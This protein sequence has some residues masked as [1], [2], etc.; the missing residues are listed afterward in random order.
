MLQG[1]RVRVRSDAPSVEREF[2]LACGDENRQRCFSAAV[3]VRAQIAI[4]S[5]PRLSENVGNVE[6]RAGYI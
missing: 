1:K 2:I 4:V 3:R 6:H 5:T